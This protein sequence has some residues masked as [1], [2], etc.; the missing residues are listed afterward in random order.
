MIDSILLGF[1]RN[2]SAAMSGAA[3]VADS[4]R[5]RTL[6]SGFFLFQVPRRQSRVDW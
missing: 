3:D 1:S 6:I 5:G 4:R 2:F